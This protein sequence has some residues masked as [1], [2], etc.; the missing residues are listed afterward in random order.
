MSK[1]SLIYTHAHYNSVIMNN[2]DE[3]IKEA[4]YNEDV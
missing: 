3:Q 4:N 2:M 1:I